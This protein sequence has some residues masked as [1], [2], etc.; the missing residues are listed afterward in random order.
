MCYIRTVYMQEHMVTCAYNEGRICHPEYIRSLVNYWA[1]KLVAAATTAYAIS[2]STIKI[3]DIW[4]VHLRMTA[5]GKS[6]LSL[7]TNNKEKEIFS[8]WQK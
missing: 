6:I 8:V 3:S 2:I 5:P 4:Q 7:H 1:C